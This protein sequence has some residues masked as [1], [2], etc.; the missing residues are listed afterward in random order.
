MDML[1]PHKGQ[2]RSNFTLGGDAGAVGGDAPEGHQGSDG[3]VEQ[4][5]GFFAVNHGA[6]Q[7]RSRFVADCGSAVGIYFINIAGCNGAGKLTL[8]TV[9]L[10]RGSGQRLLRVVAIGRKA[11]VGV[12]GEKLLP[13]R[14]RASAAGGKGQKQKC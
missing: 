4:T 11:H 8:Q 6:L 3:H 14:L 9:D 2:E 12:H 10:P 13:D 7:Q 1:A 5:T